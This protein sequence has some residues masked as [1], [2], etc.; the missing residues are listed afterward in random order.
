MTINETS[1]GIIPYTIKDNEVKYLLLK[2]RTGDWEFPKGGVDEDE[3]LQQ[4]ALRECEEEAGVKDVKIH[5]G[6][7]QT[8]NYVF[9]WD[10]EK[11]KKTVHL[12]VGKV[13][14]PENVLIS[15]EHNDYNW[16]TFNEALDKLKYESMKEALRSADLHLTVN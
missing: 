5:N 14:N 6:F 1:A 7:S 15:H 3:E 12:Y 9:E 11:I 13:F 8:Y 16:Y 10:N 2:S 4:S